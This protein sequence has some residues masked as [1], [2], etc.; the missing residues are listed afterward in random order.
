MAASKPPSRST[1]SPP[2]GPDLRPGAHRLRAPGAAVDETAAL[3]GGRLA[4]EQRRAG[5]PTEIRDIQF[6]AITTAREATLATRNT[7][8]FEGLDIPLVDPWS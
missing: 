8:H 1:S 6:A 4:A 5:R 3:I 7:R 2:A